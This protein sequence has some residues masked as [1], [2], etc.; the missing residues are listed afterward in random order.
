MI[1]TYPIVPL[2]KPRMTR[3]DKWLNPPRKCVQE[4]RDYKDQIRAYGVE[5][6]L[7]GA[8]V[9]FRMSM[10]KSWSKKKKLEYLDQPCQSKGRND[11]DNLLKALLDAVYDDDSQVWDIHV[12]KVWGFMGIITVDDG[13]DL[14]NEANN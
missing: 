10:P 14:K 6:P 1:K 9:I 11:I 3:R 7:S 8:H 4:Y 13:G 2:P 12:T 5:V